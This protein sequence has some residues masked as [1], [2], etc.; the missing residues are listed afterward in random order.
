MNGFLNS[1]TVP[2]FP[3]P[4]ARSSNDDWRTKSGYSP[5]RHKDTKSSSDAESTTEAKENTESG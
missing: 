4:E 5:P 1:P 2:N 3:K